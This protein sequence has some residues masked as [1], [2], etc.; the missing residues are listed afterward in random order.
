MPHKWKILDFLDVAGDPELAAW[1][2]RAVTIILI[3]L[4]VTG[5]PAYASVVFT[6]IRRGNIVFLE[7]IY[8]SIYAI[9]V[10]LAL[11]P[12]LNYLV[13]V[14]GLIGVSYV[15]AMAS[16][17]RLGLVGSGRLWLI[18]LPI[19]ATV[20]IGSRAGY[21]AVFLSLCIYIAFSVLASN[22]LLGGWL[23]L[24]ENPLAAGIWIEGGSALVVYIAILVI[25]VERFVSLQ[26]RTLADYR[27]SN[28]KLTETTKAL[29]ESEER[30]RT[31]GDNL[32][33]GMIYQIEGSPDGTRRFTYVSAGVERLH[34]YT[35]DQV[36]A[37]P[38]LLYKLL[39]EDDIDMMRREEERAIR[40][41]R[42]FDVEV[43]FRTRDGG[44]QWSRIVSQPRIQENDV[45]LSDGIEL[46]ITGSKQAEDALRESESRYR[47]LSEE[48][49]LKVAGR[50]DE[51]KK[52]NEDL[53]KTNRELEG[54]LSDLNAAQ[55]QLVQSEKMAALGQLAAG[56]AHELN[57]PLGAITSSIRSMV[58]VMQ[59]KVPETARL[60]PTFNEKER[61]VFET[62]LRESLEKVVRIDTLPDRATRKEIAGIL[63]DAGIRDSASV[64]A[65]IADIGAHE[66]KDRLA[67]LLT[68]DNRD[69]ILDAIS[70]LSSIRR[71]G[72]IIYVASEKAASVI[73]AL[74][75][76]MKQDTDVDVANVYVDREIDTILT[77]FHNK[78]KHG[79]S[80]R[81]SYIP[82]APVLGNRNSLNQLWI[83][84]FNNAFQT[85]NWEG[86]V[87]IEMKKNDGR[88]AV[89]ITDS[90]PGIPDEIKGRIFEPF[91]TTKKYGEGMGLGL[92]IC[93]KIVEK[94]GGTIECESVP[95]RTMFTVTLK[96]GTG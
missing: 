11:L 84:L 45:I 81:K 67:D 42:K 65:L 82:G 28:I 31:I 70:V 32:P 16:F 71:M 1:R 89:S 7:I 43:R 53:L 33:G 54:A 18:A 40:E 9:L 58:D 51:L 80:I 95:G 72:E 14:W 85:M 63:E 39:H 49:E 87:E 90:G 50:T 6:A 68:V 62:I 60:L 83:N 23:V 41:L 37:D 35:P 21:A 64:A 38:S 29:G 76:Y 92:D 12:R 27:K 47:L 26:G 93:R 78:T 73:N 69:G 57:T 55:S 77:L 66:L 15:N 17:M 75:S 48:L 8:L 61:Q 79:V 88:V 3:V 44:V 94:H 86:T 20:V 74:Q 4:A 34:G 30:L 52:A 13:R 59:R 25:L 96:A 2:S 22:G 19:I 56:I 46:D 10:I 24:R 91:F 5:L 36:Q